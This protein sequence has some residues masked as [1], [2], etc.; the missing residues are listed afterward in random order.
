M[1]RNGG[2]GRRQARRTRTERAPR[3]AGVPDLTGA[4][5][6]LVGYFSAKR[7]DFGDVMD[8]AVAELTGR[9]AEVVGRAVQRRGVSDGGVRKMHLPLSPRT[10]LRNGKV[11]EV[12]A[13]RAAT[14]ADTV[15]LLWPLT[16]RQRGLLAQELGCAVLGTRETDPGGAG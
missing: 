13:L 5:V 11:R 12:A 8:A 2:Q 7:K 3:P 4:R 9:G 14:A 10:V 16:G 15:V 6:V 1:H